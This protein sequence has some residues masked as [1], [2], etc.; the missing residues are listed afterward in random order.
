MARRLDVSLSGTLD[1]AFAKLT[2]SAPNKYCAMLSLDADH[3]VMSTSPELL[4]HHDATRGRLYTEPIKGTRPRGRDA[5]EDAALRAELSCDPKERAELAMIVDVERNDIGA[6]C[7]VGSVRVARHPYLTTTRTVHH[8]QA[9]IVGTPRR[10]VSRRTML[11]TMLPSG[12]VTG[13][14]KIRAMEVISDLEPH[15][16]G[17]YTGG[18]GY[19]AHDGST[20]LAMAIRTLVLRG[21]AGHYFTGGG[22]VIDSDPQTELTETHWKA[23]QL[24]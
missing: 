4:L 21:T 12:S 3:H 6:L 8:R 2:R 23:R 7:E 5:A 1:D 15:R 16:R 19:I 11:Q 22:I 10:D 14:P 18:F 13:A 20:K 24:G 17:L 9:L